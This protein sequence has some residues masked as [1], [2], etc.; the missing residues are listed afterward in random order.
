VVQVFACRSVSISSSAAAV[1]APVNGSEGE[2]ITVR[3]DG[4]GIMRGRIDKLREDGF[5]F[6]ILLSPDQR[7]KLAQK[8]DWLKRRQ[9]RGERDKRG[10]QRQQPADPRSTI[11]L[12]DGHILR[13][14]VIDYSRSGAAV[15]ADHLPAINSTV[16]IGALAARVV[17]HLDIGFSVKFDAVQDAEGLESLI[18]GFEPAELNGMGRRLASA[19]RSLHN[20]VGKLEIKD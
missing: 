8:I 1:T 18:T 4:L 7:R 6:T 13:C 5:V 14:F 15:S 19:A 17:R 3:F 2:Q 20:A 16:V 12:P 9:L 10:Y 11:T